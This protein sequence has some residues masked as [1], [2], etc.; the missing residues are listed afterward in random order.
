MSGI[1]KTFLTCHLKRSIFLIIPNTVKRICCCLHV[2][3]AWTR[4]ML[5]VP[6]YLAPP[7]SLLFPVRTKKGRVKKRN[8]N[9]LPLLVF[10][11][12]V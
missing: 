9:D 1:P 6:S 11:W 3:D 2:I 4:M 12:L 5:R 10:L 8:E 7:P